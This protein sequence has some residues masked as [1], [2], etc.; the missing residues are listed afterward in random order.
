MSTTP[1]PTTPTFRFQPNGIRILQAGYGYQNTDNT[2]E[3][4]RF[5]AVKAEIEDKLARDEPVYVQIRDDR[6]AGSI[7]RLKSIKFTHTPPQAQRYSYGR[8]YHSLFVSDIEVVW[9]GRKNSCKPYAG[10]VEYL[11]TWT[12]GC[13]W[14]WVKNEPKEK[15]P[16]IIPYD[17][18]EQEIQPGQFVCFVHRRYGETSMK[19]GSVTRITDKGGVFVKTL[20]LKDTDPKPDELKAYAAKD[21]IIVDKALMSRLT[22]A[23]LRTE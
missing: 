8:N 1:T 11:P 21:L 13:V 6:R 16:K 12:G 5:L 17:H 14:N 3:I 10:E 9:D 2:T 15:V 23:R 4:N 22:L 7:G 19:F 20:K 18:L